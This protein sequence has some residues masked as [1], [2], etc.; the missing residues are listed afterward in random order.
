MTKTQASFSP[1]CYGTSCVTLSTCPAS[2]FLL[3][4]WVLTSFQK[5]CVLCQ[6]QL[7]SVACNLSDFYFQR[8]LLRSAW[9]SRQKGLC[10]SLPSGEGDEEDV[11]AEGRQKEVGPS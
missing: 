4:L 9:T 6:A 7:P 11:Q 1:C 3:H 10:Q 2:D 5:P 8:R